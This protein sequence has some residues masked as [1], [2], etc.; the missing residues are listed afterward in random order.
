[1]LPAGLGTP[2]TFILNAVA[3]LMVIVPLAIP[4]VRGE[5]QP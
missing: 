1:L 4:L 2:L 5:P 3:A